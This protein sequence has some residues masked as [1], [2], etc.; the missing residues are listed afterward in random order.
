MLENQENAKPTDMATKPGT[1]HAL[2]YDVGV[3]GRVVEQH[4]DGTVTLELLATLQRVKARRVEVMVR[5]GP[6]E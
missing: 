4:P 1:K 6:A 3:I 5:V 2:H